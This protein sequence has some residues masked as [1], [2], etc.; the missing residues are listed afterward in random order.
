MNTVT[1]TSISANRV[2]RTKVTC[3]GTVVSKNVTINQTPIRTV[4][5]AEQ[6]WLGFTMLKFQKF[7]F[8]AVSEIALYLCEIIIRNFK[9]GYDT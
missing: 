9:A 8:S 4:D 1:C 6:F 7:R 5:L 3:D 2:C